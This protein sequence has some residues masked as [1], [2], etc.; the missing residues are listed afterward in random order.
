MEQFNNTGLPVLK[1]LV[2]SHFPLALPTENFDTSEKR[3]LHIVLPRSS[4]VSDF[5]FLLRLGEL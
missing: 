4:R 1:Y 5:V 3:R 2:A